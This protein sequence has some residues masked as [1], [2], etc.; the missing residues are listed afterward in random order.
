MRNGRGVHR[1]E[2]LPVP[3]LP[4]WPRLLRED[5]AS[6]LMALRACLGVQRAAEP[7]LEHQYWTLLAARYGS[8]ELAEAVLDRLDLDRERLVDVEDG[9]R[10]LLLGCLERAALEQAELSRG[11]QRR[12]RLHVL[13]LAETVLEARERL[14]V[15]AALYALAHDG[16]L[17]GED[18]FSCYERVLLLFKLAHVLFQIA[19]SPADRRRRRCIEAARRARDGARALRE[20]HGA[21]EEEIR[22]LL[23]E[24]QIWLGH[25]QE[26]MGDLAAASEAFLAAVPWSATVDDRV[27]CTT[28][29]ASALAGL[30][31]RRKASELLRSVEAELDR[32]EDP[33]VRE[34]WELVAW[35]LEGS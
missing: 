23:L 25:K 15:A 21:P 34:L 22:L 27:T 9:D 12:V 30:G 16:T 10:L 7:E 11:E 26:E 1:V 4:D 29:A 18:P 33:V 28:R 2:G 35:D 24:L 3:G 20:V 31:E 19:Q 6:T 14:G 8:D 17:G 5:P 32:V 13:L